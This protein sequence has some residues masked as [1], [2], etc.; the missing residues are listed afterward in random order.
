MHSLIIFDARDHMHRA[1][2]PGT[3]QQ[4]SFIKEYM[5]GEIGINDGE[6]VVESKGLHLYGCAEDLAKLRCLKTKGACPFKAQQEAIEESIFNGFNSKTKGWCADNRKQQP[7]LKPNCSPKHYCL[8]IFIV[9]GFPVT[10][11]T[12][13][14]EKL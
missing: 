12:P 6:M 13:L 10:A 14:I 9:A 1:I 5:A 2:A 8:L 3:G 11:Q 4:V 7:E